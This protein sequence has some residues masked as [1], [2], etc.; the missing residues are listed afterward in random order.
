MSDSFQSPETDPGRVA[1]A[2]LRAGETHDGIAGPAFVGEEAV[3]YNSDGSVSRG[4]LLNLLVAHSE[5]GTAVVDVDHNIVLFNQRAVDLGLLRDGLADPVAE[6]V[7]EVFATGVDRHFDYVPPISAMGF[8]STGRTMPRTIENVRCVVRLAEHG[9]SRYALVYGDDDST[10]LRVEATRRDFAANVSHELKTP[11]G[12]I[13]LM[14]EAML[15]SRD[16]P[17]AVDHFGHR[18]LHEATRMSTLIN[19]LIGLSRLQEGRIDQFSPIDVDELVE[20]ALGS[21]A[22][23]AEV[24]QIELVCD[25]PTGF[26]VPGDRT[27]LLT[28]LNNL[29]VNAVNHSQPGE[30]VS[31]S[32]KLVHMDEGTMVAVAVTDRGIGIAA[33]DQQR[34]F[35]R[36]FRVDKARSRATG[37]TGL[38][39]AI[40]KHVAASHGGHI[41]LWSKP[42]T[43]ST[44]TLYIPISTSA[45][46]EEDAL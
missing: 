14:T 17:Q 22:V 30:V 36:F 3:T 19:E 46:S 4:G 27:L 1:A 44:F 12:A 15:E 26:T 7:S 37:G 21:A 28:A 20:D 5:S 42:G 43:G 13:S 39:L 32:R 10:N 34:V 8:V 45:D 33:S 9:T 18:V 23:S 40:V 41:G 2:P 6:V 16:D 24:A 35:E 31:V 29:I 38:G 25:E 11:L